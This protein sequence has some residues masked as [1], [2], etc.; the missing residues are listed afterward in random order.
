MHQK[1]SQPP[2]RRET[3][4]RSA[5]P[6]RARRTRPSRVRVEP[7]RGFPWRGLAAGLVAWLAIVAA[8]VAL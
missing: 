8:C 1:R 6:P 4:L 7:H 2:G 5:P 3:A